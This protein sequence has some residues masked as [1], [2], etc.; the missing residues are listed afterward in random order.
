MANI[1]K[2]T[3]KFLSDLRINNH[4]DWFQQNRKRYEE[5]GT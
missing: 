5:A 3:F 1:N 4:R 2:T